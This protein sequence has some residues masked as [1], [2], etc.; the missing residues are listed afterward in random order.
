[1]KYEE[2]KPMSREAAMKAFAS[3][4]TDVIID[5]LL[6]VVHHDEDWKW[7]Q[8]LCLGYLDNEVQDIKELA[9]ICLGHIARLHNTLDMNIVLPKLQMLATD[10]QVAGKVEDALDDIM[11]F[12]K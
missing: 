4:D 9:I 11:M 7:K 2:V 12:V 6:R 10:P 5:A 1:M 8:E 3:N